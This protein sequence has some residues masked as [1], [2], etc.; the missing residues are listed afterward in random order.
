[1][2]M[3][4]IENRKFKCCLKEKWIAKWNVLDLDMDQEIVAETVLQFLKNKK[5][6]QWC[7]K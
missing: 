1:M 7:I 3:T 6:Y 2:F 4:C 5:N